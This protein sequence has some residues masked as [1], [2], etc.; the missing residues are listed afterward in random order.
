MNIKDELW[1]NEGRPWTKELQD[2]IRKVFKNL[3]RTKHPDKA[4]IN[5]PVDPNDPNKAKT[6]E[7]SEQMAKENYKPIVDAWCIIEE[8]IRAFEEYREKSK[9]APGRVPQWPQDFT[10]PPPKGNF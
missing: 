2:R 9:P 3:A 10:S 1:E 7:E 8:D 5:F 4:A 6:R